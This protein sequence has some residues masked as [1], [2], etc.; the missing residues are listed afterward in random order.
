MQ[1]L[2]VR[3]KQSLDFYSNGKLLISGEYVVMDGA[4]SLAL[5]VRF[6][7]SLHVETAGVP[8]RMHWES[9]VRGQ[10]W[11][12]A[13]F[14]LP[15]LKILSTNDQQVAVRLQTLLGNASFLNPHILQQHTA[16]N[17]QADI[18]FDL[19]TGLGSSSTL[20]SNVAWWFDADPFQLFRNTYTG[21]GYDIACA[22]SSRAILYRL[23][24]RIP[25]IQPVEFD[26]PFRHYIYF[27]HLGKKQDTHS[28]IQHYRGAGQ[29]SPEEMERISD[30]SVQL[31]K[32]KELHELENLLTE[33]ETII[34][35]ILGMEPVKQ[36]LFS[37]FHGT[38]KSLGA[39]GG[40]FILVTWSGR[41]KEMEDYFHSKGLKTIYSFNELIL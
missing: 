21:S 14:Q 32:A 7:Q 3:M 17:V 41:R 28:G 27:V 35:R 23:A 24:D 30:I 22:R 34:G 8:S 15:D 10:E 29:A 16:I 37:D 1:V 33:H 13:D 5:P 40:D 39:W 12:M 36:T 11:F 18:G 6:G 20:I 31:V 26:P 38:V 9:S 2:S 25:V 19:D 4:L